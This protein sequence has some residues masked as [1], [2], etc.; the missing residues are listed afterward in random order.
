MQRRETF[1]LLI[2]TRECI[3]HFARFNARYGFNAG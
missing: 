1:I 3:I 2:E